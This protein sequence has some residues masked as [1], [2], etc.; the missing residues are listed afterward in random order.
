MN[1]MIAW[2]KSRPLV[3]RIVAVSIGTASGYLLAIIYWSQGLVFSDY[4]YARLFGLAYFVIALIFIYITRNTYR[5]SD[6]DYEFSPN[7]CPFARQKADQGIYE[8][9]G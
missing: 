3:L 1:I 6:F 2:K 4:L 5:I 9:A 7:Y 8:Q